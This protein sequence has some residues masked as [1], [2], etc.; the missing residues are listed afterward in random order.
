MSCKAL[1]A[2]R[3]PSRCD[4]PTFG[5]SSILTRTDSQ[6]FNRYAAASDLA[7]EKNCLFTHGR[8]FLM[9]GSAIS[10]IRDLI[11]AG[12]GLCKLIIKV[13]VGIR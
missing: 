12:S 4:R 8:A 2:E 3:W 5:S 7:E 13:I 11:C 6:G 1:F 10:S 9:S